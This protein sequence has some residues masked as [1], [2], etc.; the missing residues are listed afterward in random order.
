[1]LVTSMNHEATWNAVVRC[2]VSYSVLSDPSGDVATKFWTADELAAH[3]FT[4]WVLV[5]AR[6]RIRGFGEQL[7]AAP[8]WA[9]VANAAMEGNSSQTLVQD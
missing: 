5:D 6:G 3:T 7:P 4:G 8:N 9:A 2:D 1:M